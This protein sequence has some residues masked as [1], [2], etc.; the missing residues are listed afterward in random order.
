[1]Y[2]HIVVGSN[3]QRQVG[4]GLVVSVASRGGGASLRGRTQL[5]FEHVVAH[6]VI[7]RQLL[8]GRVNR[9]LHRHT[10]ENMG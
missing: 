10:G 6:T 1:M 3:A 4:G 9:L 7:G 2:R 5:V 8:L